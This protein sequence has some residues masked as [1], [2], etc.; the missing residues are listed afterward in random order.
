MS[1]KGNL[2][3]LR[4]KVNPS[5]KAFAEQIGINYT[6]YLSYENGIWPNEK[7]LVAIASA[8]HVSIDTLLGHSVKRYDE[9]KKIVQEIVTEDGTLYRVTEE[10]PSVVVQICDKVSGEELSR[11]SFSSKQEFVHFMKRLIQINE[12]SSRLML[13]QLI[14][15]LLQLRQEEIE[16]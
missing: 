7:T 9:Y 11:V 5:A 14:M 4:L 13:H 2:R 12:R 3:R 15:D 10:A 6:K 1:L 16:E 8:L